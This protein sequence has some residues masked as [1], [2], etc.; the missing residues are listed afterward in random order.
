VTVVVGQAKVADKCPAEASTFTR[1]QE[2]GASALRIARTLLLKVV[3]S[4]SS[5]RPM[6]APE[7]R[8]LEG[9]GSRDTVQDDRVR[10]NPCEH[11]P[12]ARRT[13]GMSDQTTGPDASGDAAPDYAAKHNG[14]QQAF[15]KRTNEFAAKEQA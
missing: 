9:A 8:D 14:L 10:S 1:C 15:Q 11:R 6:V 12:P 7:F 5:M 3:K 13:L 4:S 2:S